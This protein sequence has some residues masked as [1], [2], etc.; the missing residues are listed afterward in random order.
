MVDRASVTLVN[1]RVIAKIKNGD[2]LQCVDTR[3][4]GIDRA[5][6]WWVWAW[7]WIRQDSRVHMLDRVDETFKEAH[8]L[9]KSKYPCLDEH[10]K[11]AQHGIRELMCTYADDP[12]TVSRLETLIGSCPTEEENEQAF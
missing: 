3:Y 9:E 4:F 6:G 8:K 1:L 5:T 11:A 10:I 7:R 12:T 2:R